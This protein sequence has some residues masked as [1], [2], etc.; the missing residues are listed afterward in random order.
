LSASEK[1]ESLFKFARSVNAIELDRNAV[2]EANQIPPSVFV[3]LALQLKGQH[4][5]PNLSTVELK[6][7]DISAHYFPLLLSPC[8]GELSVEFVHNSQLE[9]AAICPS[10][11][12]SKHSFELTLSLL[13]D[14]LVSASRTLQ[15]LKLK[16]IPSV[17]HLTLDSV[18]RFRHLRVLELANFIEVRRFTDLNFVGNFPTLEDLSFVAKGE[19]YA[20]LAPSLPQ[21]TCLP[22]LKYLRITA[23]SEILLDFLPNIASVNLKHLTFNELPPGAMSERLNLMKKKKIKVHPVRLTLLE[24]LSSR[25]P[26]SLKELVVVSPQNLTCGLQHLVRLWVLENLVFQ[27]C[28]MDGIFNVFVES[29]GFRNS[30][31]SLCLTGAPLPFGF[32]KQIAEYAPS[33]ITLSLPLDITDTSYADNM[34]ATNHPLRSLEIR[35]A[36]T[37]QPEVNGDNFMQL[38]R[39]ARHLNTLF[40]DIQN[41]TASTRE[42]EWEKVWQLVKLCQDSRR[43][44]DS[45]K[46]AE[47]E[48]FEVI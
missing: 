32:L 41:L 29:S 17:T 11:E 23:T 25:W 14:D 21:E 2:Q 48:S 10:S 24:I 26:R 31:R 5:F 19:H 34:R 36:A 40:P 15:S 7:F 6:N 27:G 18:S 22:S 42:S 43:T 33:L 13:L 9:D 16:N 1:W 28:S 30:L 20:R 4:L 35:H 12:G 3:R 47:G 44:K 38:V 45:G 8:L 39:V 46:L 37:H